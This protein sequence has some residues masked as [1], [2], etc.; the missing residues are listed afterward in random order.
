MQASTPLIW[1]RGLGLGA[2]PNSVTVNGSPQT[3]ELVDGE[4][5]S[6]EGIP[7]IR[8]N[9]DGIDNQSNLTDVLFLLIFLFAA[10]EAPPC[11]AAC[12]AEANGVLEVAD[13]FVM[14][15]YYF[16]GGPPPSAPFP[17]CGSIFSIGIGTGCDQATGDCL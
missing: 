1:D 8:G 4:Y 2:T 5:L 16:L 13:V 3:V 10:G 7:F 11:D 6:V 12:D 9:C 17:E 15:N 14:L